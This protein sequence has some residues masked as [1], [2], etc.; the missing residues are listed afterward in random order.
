MEKTELT[1][2]EILVLNSLKD[3]D[4]YDDLPTSSV[5]NLTES[6]GICTKSIRGVLS[7]LIKKDLVTSTTYPN[8]KIA[9][10]YLYK[11]IPCRGATAKRALLTK[12]G[13]TAVPNANVMKELIKTMKETMGRLYCLKT[14]WDYDNLTLI[15]SS[16]INAYCTQLFINNGD[17]EKALQILQDQVSTFTFKFTENA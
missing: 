11:Q 13:G 15:Q 3:Q 8:G 17:E 2:L 7:S 12:N 6:T 9:F 14:G 10:Q 1:E 16:L 4:E 5:G